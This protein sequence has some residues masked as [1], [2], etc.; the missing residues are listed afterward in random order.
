[1]LSPLPSY[2]SAYLCEGCYRPRHQKIFNMVNPVRVEDSS[3]AQN[4]TFSFPGQ[5][6]LSSSPPGV[7]PN[8]YPLSSCSACPIEHLLP[9]AKPCCNNHKSSQ[10]NPVLISYKTPCKYHSRLIRKG[11]SKRENEGREMR[12]G[13]RRDETRRKGSWDWEREEKDLLKREMWS[14]YVKPGVTV[15]CSSSSKIQV[16]ENVIKKYS[17]YPW[18]D[19]PLSGARNVSNTLSD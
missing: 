12:E 2:S 17:K 5:G 15:H 1:M 13:E 7:S 9:T 11:I 10:C 18:K 6:A 14:R 19:G 4:K 8:C 3:V 16:G